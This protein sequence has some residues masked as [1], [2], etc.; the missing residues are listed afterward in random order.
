MLTFNLALILLLAGDVS[1]NP[2]PA[3]RRNIRF[4]TTNI[5]SI[6]GKIASRNEWLISKTT[7]I[8]AINETLLIPHDTA[9]C[10]CDTS[11]PGYTF[12]HRPCPVR[13]CDG[14]RVVISKLF[15]VNMYTSPDYYRFESICVDL[16]KSY[17]SG[18]FICI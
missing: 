10:L 4:A 8:L 15:K 7:D 16:S 18:Y 5:R 2:G 12:Q 17:F 1:L 3:V 14:V 9:A 6:Q 11:P 13:R